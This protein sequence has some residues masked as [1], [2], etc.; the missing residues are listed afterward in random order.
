MGSGE[1]GVGRNVRDPVTPRELDDEVVS[2]VRLVQ[3]RIVTDSDFD[4]EELPPPAALTGYVR[5][6]WRLRAPAGD[7][8]PP[9]P[10]VPDGCVELVLNLADPFI[11]HTA[12]GASHVQ[13]LRLITGQIT[14]AVTIAPSGRS[15]LWGIRFHPWAA[16]SFLGY[17]APSCATA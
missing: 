10:I 7:P 3:R 17:M 14:R 1:W 6:I 2:E 16:A 9:E 8:A 4:Y 15:D 12:P 5:C 13:P 11:R